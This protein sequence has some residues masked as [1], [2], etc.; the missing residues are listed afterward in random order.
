MGFHY[1][2]WVQECYSRVPSCTQ[3]HSFKRHSSTQFL[4]VRVVCRLFFCRLFL[5]FYLQIPLPFAAVAPWP[6]AAF[7]LP[8]LLFPFLFLPPMEVLPVSDVWQGVF[9]NKKASVIYTDWS[10]DFLWLS[11]GSS[12]A[13][14]INQSI[15]QSL[16]CSYM[17][18]F[19]LE[20]VMRFFW[21][22]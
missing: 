10:S 2:N 14:S 3:P 21:K 19:L 5:P 6:Q 1:I 16:S 7:L 17:S 13:L 4:G 20:M 12:I 22:L 11:W 8:F 15:N 18:D 9:R